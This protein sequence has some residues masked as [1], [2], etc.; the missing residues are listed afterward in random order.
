[1][2]HRFLHLHTLSLFFTLFAFLCSCAN[3]THTDEEI[4]G[5]NATASAAVVSTATPSSDI[6]SASVNSN[7]TDADSICSKTTDSDN[8]DYANRDF[9]NTV[10][11]NPYSSM[12]MVNDTLYFHTGRTHNVLRCGLMDGQITSTVPA[13]MTPSVNDQSN[14]GTGY[15]YQYGTHGTID[16]KLDDN[17]YVFLEMIKTDVSHIKLTNH[18]TKETKELSRTLFPEDFWRVLARYD[19][20]ETVQSENQTTDPHP[21]YSLQLYD[22][23]DNL[24]HTILPRGQFVEIDGI[25]YED[26]SQNTTTD[27]FLTVDALWEED[28]PKAAY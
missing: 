15:G 21:S 12:V 2:K 20:L 24:L 13:T 7:H 16:I 6:D 10:S 25:R 5:I 22:E 17:W 14:F 23:S 1:M 8:T 9:A 27:F 28:L 19:A 26:Y 4:S 18:I 11:T 3:V